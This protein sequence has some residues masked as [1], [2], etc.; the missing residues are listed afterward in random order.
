MCGDTQLLGV[1]GWPEEDN[2]SL[3]E[4]EPG[5]SDLALNQEATFAP[6]NTH[7]LLPEAASKTP[8]R[9][10]SLCSRRADSPEQATRRVVLT[11]SLP[12]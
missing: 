10:L 5:G 2:V 4:M 3:N 8:A 9:R 6:S 11:D 12:C 7:L 1:G